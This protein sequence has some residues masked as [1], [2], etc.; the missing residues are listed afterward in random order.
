MNCDL[1]Q[2]GVRSDKRGFERVSMT[3]VNGEEAGPMWKAL[4]NPSW[5]ARAEIHLGGFNIVDERNPRT[6]DILY[7]SQVTAH[8]GTAGSTSKAAPRE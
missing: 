8:Q 2:T 3:A 4:P 7:Q 6:Y 1:S 5:A